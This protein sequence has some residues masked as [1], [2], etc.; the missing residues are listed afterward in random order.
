MRNDMEEG[1]DIDEGVSPCQPISIQGV[2]GY[3]TYKIDESTIGVRPKWVSVKKQPAPKEG[4]FLFSYH[5]GVGL[6]SW[7][8]A[9]TTINGNSERTHELYFLVLCPMDITE[10]ECEPMQW[11]EEKMVEMDVYWMPVPLPKE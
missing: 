6:A 2:E 11:N 9:Y 10:N 1:F 5:C 3:E 8:Q 7:G 4:K